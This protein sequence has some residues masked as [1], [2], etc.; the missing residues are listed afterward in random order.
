MMVEFGIQIDDG[1]EKLPQI[2]VEKNSQSIELYDWQR[3]AIEFFLNHHK[4]IYEVSTGA[5]KT[6]CAIEILK[7]LLEV[8][9][10]L[11]TLI[12]VPKNVILETTWF[13]ELYNA[14]FSLVDIG[15]FYGGIKEYGKKFTITNMQNLEKI[16]LEIFD[17]VCYDEIHN[18]GTKRLLKYVEHP[19]K[20]KIG[21]SATV[22]RMDNAHWK[23][24]EIFD[25]NIFKY[26]PNQALEEGVLNPF[27]FI[28]IGVIMDEEN[29][30]KY[31]IL[32]QEI[33]MILQAGGGFKRIMRMASGL[34]FK[35]LKKM[36]ERKELVN[37]YYRKFDVV[38]YICKKHRDDKII[39]FNQFN[40]QTNKCYWHL[41][42]EGIK[43]RVMHSGIS[44]E[45]RDENLIDF[46][47]DKF[48]ALLTSKILDEGYNLPSI[49]VGV[50]M[51]GDSTAKQ[52]IQ[53]MG[54]VLRRKNKPSNLYQVY[55][56]ETIEEEYGISR[57][58]LFKELCNK[59]EQYTYDGDE[60]VG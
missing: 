51:A 35:M 57:A 53:R 10:T 25:Y 9:P 11:N 26:T 6:V 36:N 48:N 8:E 38:K 56:K 5:G 46:K 28:N 45:K 50:I 13:K 32:T 47:N 24:F 27:N 29:Y 2:V 16:Q 15:V 14:G 7:K 40:K 1:S 60:L 44:K 18:Y 12:I 39:V 41:L 17:V 58:K 59:Y 19:F 21:L 54:R 20:Y 43:A 52:T 33:N 22:E 30:E 37:N 3:R 55:C 4:V 42:D 49:D 23:I 34:K 31:T